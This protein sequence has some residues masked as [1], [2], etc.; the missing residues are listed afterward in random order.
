MLA[1]NAGR[2]YLTAFFFILRYIFSMT[3]S[4][5]W[6]SFLFE[7]IP[8]KNRGKV[9]GFLQTGQRG[10]RATGTLAGGYIF[11]TIGAK[12][13]PIAMIAYPVAGLIPLIISK[14]M[15]KK[16]D[17]TEEELGDNETNEIPVEAQLESGT[18]FKSK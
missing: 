13:F 11:D 16:L 3:P 4:A 2:F 15:K 14:I 8:P 6:N 18:E 17:L 1:G 10:L 12:V 9:M 5:A 7:W